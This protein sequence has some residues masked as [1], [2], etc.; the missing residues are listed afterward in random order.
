MAT[1]DDPHRLI[2]DFK[3]IFPPHP[4]IPPSPPPLNNGV[5]FPPGDSE[6]TNKE[7]TKRE[8][9]LEQFKPQSEEK[10]EQESSLSNS[11]PLSITVAIGCSLL[12]IN[13]LLFSAVYYQRRRIQRLNREAIEQEHNDQNDFP[14]I[15]HKSQRENTAIKE[16][17][18]RDLHLDPHSKPNIQ[19]NPLYTVISK[20]PCDLAQE[21]SHESL[22]TLSCASS[23]VHQKN[24]VNH[25]GVAPPTIPRDA[26]VIQRDHIPNSKYAANSSSNLSKEKM[27][28]VRNSTPTHDTIT[29]V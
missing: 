16:P 9:S 21:S 27:N 24:A 14:D 22:S 28:N 13:I 15:G 26:P 6:Y 23:G 10:A 5:Y 18:D 20:S 7:K 1:F 19:S 29:V 25:K 17:P 4:P 11:V 12:F 8:D 3:K 2:T